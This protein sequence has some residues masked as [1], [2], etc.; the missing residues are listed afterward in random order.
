M[1]SREHRWVCG[2]VLAAARQL[3]VDLAVAE[4]SELAEMPLER[5]AADEGF[6]I[7]NTPLG[8]LVTTSSSF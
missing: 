2:T 7:E 1:P 8:R 6:H 3:A 5:P 4:P